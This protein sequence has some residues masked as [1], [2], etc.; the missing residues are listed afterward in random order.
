MPVDR[1]EPSPEMVRFVEAVQKLWPKATPIPP[2]PYVC[3]QAARRRAMRLPR[4][5]EDHHMP[6]SIRRDVVFTRIVSLTPHDDSYCPHGCQP[7]A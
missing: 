2:G 1:P 7:P 6:V 4:L 3:P 5:P